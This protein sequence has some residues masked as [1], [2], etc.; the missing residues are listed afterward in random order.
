MNSTPVSEGADAAHLP[1]KLSYRADVDGLRAV[2]VLPVIFFHAGLEFMAGGYVG[3]DVFFVISGYLITSIIMDEMREGTFSYLGFYDRRIRRIFPALFFVLLVSLP[4]GLYLLVPKH[5]E[6]FGQSVI[7]TVAF[8]SNFFFYLEDGYFDQPA[9]LHPLLHTWS[10]AVEEQF[11]LL[12]PLLLGFLVRRR[13]ALVPS[14][15]VVAVLSFLIGLWQLRVDP[16]GAFYLLPGRFW[17]LLLGSLLAV[18]TVPAIRSP[19][20]AATGVLAGL[21]AIGAA[22]LL[23]DETTTFPGPAAL[24][25][26]LGTA[27]VILAGRTPNLISRL[28]GSTPLRTVGLLSYSLYLWH[29]PLMVFARHVLVRPFTALEIALL[30][31][32]TFLLAAFSWRYVEQPFRAR[33]RRIERKRLFQL[34][35]T[36]AA[37][38]IAFGVY[39]DL[40]D[41]AP[42]RF[43][44]P[45]GEYLAA[46]QDRDVRCLREGEACELGDP[47]AS[48]Q[49]LLWGDSHASMLMPTFRDLSLST[50]IPGRTILKS[51]CPPL[52]GYPLDTPKGAECR[53]HNDAALERIRT[54]G[55]GTLYL[56]GRW[57]LQV[58]ASRYGF[59]S[60][61]VPSF[62]DTRK[63]G[64]GDAELIGLALADTLSALAPLPLRVVI[65]GPVPEVGWHVPY[66]LAQQSR[67][68]ALLDDVAIAPSR[69]DFMARNGQ[70]LALL[71]R[72]AG[73]YGVPVLY[74][75]RWLCGETRC[76]VTVDG[77]PLY[78]DT[79]HLTTLGAGLL[80]NMLRPSFAEMEASAPVAIQQTDSRD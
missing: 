55:V 1:V 57:T 2:A 53:E 24:I 29:F 21:V 3:V 14:L 4:A 26:C 79:D 67:F 10:L 6:D 13:W 9:D 22:V 38:G 60:G 5:L 61:P 25:P 66:V 39:T 45:A 18:S 68:G 71:E 48:P 58:E 15:S 36:G 28:L 46:S 63:A 8:V 62:S 78:Y 35:A 20:L 72:V 59:E 75:D 70:T 44:G 51:A 11:Y 32:A 54:S 47:G 65:V 52:L 40:A 56:V 69:A 73:E 76:A 37:V 17:E 49:Y 33:P 30:V 12:F 42:E 19:L 34:A 41:G 74:P 27:L 64:A 23:Y 16:N 7:A 80:R 50:G 43:T 77:Q 31:L